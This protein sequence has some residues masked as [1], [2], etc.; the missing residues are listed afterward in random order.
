MA[1]PQ[2]QF[3]LRDLC[4]AL[5]KHQQLH[6]GKWTVGFEFTLLAGN[7]GQNTQ[8]AKPGSMVVITKANLS[9]PQ[10]NPPFELSYTVDAE[11]VNPPPAKG[12]AKPSKATRSKRSPS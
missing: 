1:D 4:I 8:D 10:Q 5:I 11:E 3:D 9:K 2:Y 12:R 7:F 6:T